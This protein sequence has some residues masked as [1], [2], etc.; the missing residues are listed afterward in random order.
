M[1]CIF[2]DRYHLKLLILVINSDPQKQDNN[3]IYSQI[4]PLI[5]VAVTGIWFILL[6]LDFESSNH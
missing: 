3:K 1:I 5:D 4:Q 2:I 6:Y